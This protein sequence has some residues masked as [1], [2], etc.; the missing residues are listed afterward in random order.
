MA[1]N[2]GEWLDGANP[3]PVVVK[4]GGFLKKVAGHLDP[5]TTSIGGLV[6]FQSARGVQTEAVVKGGKA[7]VEVSVNTMVLPKDKKA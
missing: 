3:P 7:V 4:I 5:T 6:D 2:T 1:E